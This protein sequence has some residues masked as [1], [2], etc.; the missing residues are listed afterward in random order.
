M[1]K[2]RVVVGVRFVPG[3]N[4][5]DLVRWGEL[6]TTHAQPVD[7]DKLSTVSER[8]VL[9]KLAQGHCVLTL[10]HGGR[11]GPNLKLVKQ[12]RLHIAMDDPTLTL[13]HLEAF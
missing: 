10:L 9:R 6:R 7:W 2:Q 3:S 11:L 8:A 4:V 13:Q 5:V 1:N 12:P